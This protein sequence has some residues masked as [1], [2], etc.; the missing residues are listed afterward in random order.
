M[1]GGHFNSNGYIYYQVSQFVDELEHA[2]EN[3]DRKDE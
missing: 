3:N 2:I 1:S